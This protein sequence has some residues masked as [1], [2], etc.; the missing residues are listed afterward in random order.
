MQIGQELKMVVMMLGERPELQIDGAFLKGSSSD[1]LSLEMTCCQVTP[2]KT[3]PSQDGLKVPS[4]KHSPSFSKLTWDLPSSTL[5]QTSGPMEAQGK[6]PLFQHLLHGPGD[7]GSD[8]I[9]P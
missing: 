9:P 7:L 4:E 2:W 3:G 5:P 8:V 1:V 6:V